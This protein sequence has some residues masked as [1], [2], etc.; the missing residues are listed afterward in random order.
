MINVSDATFRREP[1]AVSAL[2]APT[3]CS[4]TRRS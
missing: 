2:A 1:G 3:H 4:A